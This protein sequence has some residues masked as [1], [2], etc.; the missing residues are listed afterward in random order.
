M[1]IDEEAYR[2]GAISAELYG[3]LK[4][5]FER[6]YIRGGKTGSSINEKYAQEAIAQDIID[7]MEEDWFYIIGPGTTTRPIMEKLKLDYTLLGIDLIHNKKLI[8]KD[9]NEKKLIKYIRGKET[10]LVVTPIG[11][12]GFLF[13]RGNQQLSSEVIREVGADNI[14]VI[15]TKQ[16]INSLSG[17]PFI[18]DSGD[19]DLDKSLSG[20][21]VVTTGYKEKVVYRVE[22]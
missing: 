17:Q 13:G 4:I 12:Q 5:P 21:I 18:V 2:A 3:Y 20:H 7:N 11:G 1:D 14:I 8:E 16:K 22:T 6:E 9:L 19:R 15:A 10:K